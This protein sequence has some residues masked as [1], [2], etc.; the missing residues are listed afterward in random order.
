[1]PPPRSQSKNESKQE[2][3]KQVRKGSKSSR[4]CWNTADQWWKHHS[5]TFPFKKL[6]TTKIQVNVVRV[7]FETSVILTTV[8]FP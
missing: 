3:K 8:I 7:L 6:E 1:M 5:N 4:S 2:V